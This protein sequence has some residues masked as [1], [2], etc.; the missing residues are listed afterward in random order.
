[1]VQAA[2]ALDVGAYIGTHALLMGRL[3]GPEGRVYAFEPQR[4]AYRELRRNIELNVLG[5]VTALRYAVGAETRIVEMNPPKETDL[6]VRTEK[7]E[8][9]KTGRIPGESGL[10]VDAGGE[11]AE[12]RPLGSF[13]FRNVSVLK[14]D[15]EGFEDEVWPERKISSAKAGR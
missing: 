3:A 7:G 9:D 11:R 15:V 10:S 6:F 4:K 12:L 1:M 5:N 14:I 2:L 13:G 8:W